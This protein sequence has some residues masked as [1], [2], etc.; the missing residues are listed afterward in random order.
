MSLSLPLRLSLPIRYLSSFVQSPATNA[1]VGIRK[2]ENN[3]IIMKGRQREKRNAGKARNKSN[4]RFSRFGFG[5][6]YR[7]IHILSPILHWR[8]KQNKYNFLFYFP[9]Q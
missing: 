7:R 3:E 4:K 1:F 2:K 6:I 8:P 5:S 9:K